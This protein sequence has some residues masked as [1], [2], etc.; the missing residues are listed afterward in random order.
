MFNY[1][2]RVHDCDG[3]DYLSV[4]LRPSVHPSVCRP[5]VRSVPP[6]FSK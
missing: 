3:L 6:I 2:S 1:F 4:A 5:S